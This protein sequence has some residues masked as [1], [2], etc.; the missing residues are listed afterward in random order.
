MRTRY[1]VLL[2]GLAAVLWVVVNLPASILRFVIAPSFGTLITPVGTLWRGSSQFVTP[3]GI[4]A[5]LQWHTTLR[6]P[7]VSFALIDAKTSIQGRLE[8]SLSNIRAS[9]S[10]QLDSQ[11]LAPLLAQ[12]DLFVPGI[13]D[14]R[15]TNFHFG[16]DRLTMLSPSQLQWSGG[17][18]RYILANRRYDALM[19]PLFA[20]ITARDDGALEANVTLS[21][22][23]AAP[24]LILR[25]NPSGSVYL[26]VTR[27]MLRLA[28]YPWTGNEAETE[29][30]FEVERGLAQPLT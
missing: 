9:L 5:K 4:E 24:L 8:P 7:G 17:Q 6:H 22:A 10:G 25:L 23:D 11:T 2:L 29:L 30:I 14:L 21:P 12:Y 13:F 26:G 1:S 20:S 28:N 15:P 16:A 18:V 19:P 3:L 27:G